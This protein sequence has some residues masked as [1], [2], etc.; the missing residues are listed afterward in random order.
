MSNVPPSLHCPLTGKVRAKCDHC[1]LGIADHPAKMLYCGETGNPCSEC[2]C[3][4]CKLRRIDD[5]S[6][7]KS[8]KPKVQQKSAHEQ[9]AAELLEQQRRFAD[10]RVRHFNNEKMED[11]LTIQAKLR[12]NKANQ[13]QKR[14]VKGAT[15]EAEN[16]KTVTFKVFLG[17]AKYGP[18]VSLVSS[19]ESSRFGAVDVEAMYGQIGD[20]VVNAVLTQTGIRGRHPN[21]F[22]L[23]AHDKSRLNLAKQ[24]KQWFMIETKSTSQKSRILYLCLKNET[25]LIPHSVNS[26]PA[27]SPPHTA[28]PPTAA[29]AETA[30]DLHYRRR[31]V[32]KRAI[33]PLLSNMQEE[34]LLTSEADFHQQYLQRNGIAPRNVGDF[35]ADEDDW[36]FDPAEEFFDAEEPPSKKQCAESAA[37]PVKKHRPPIKQLME[38]GATARPPPV[39]FQEGAGSGTAIYATYDEAI[40]GAFQLVEPVKSGSTKDVW[41][42][43]QV[44]HHLFEGTTWVLKKPK[45]Q[46]PNGV[47]LDG[48]A[49]LRSELHIREIVN[50]VCDAWNNEN[51]VTNHFI[52]P[53]MIL[54]T[55]CGCVSGVLKNMEELSNVW[56]FEQQI[57]GALEKVITN[58]GEVNDKLRDDYPELALSITEDAES[59]IHKSYAVLEGK[60]L[61]LDVELLMTATGPRYILD[62]QIC[63]WGTFKHDFQRFYGYGNSG[64]LGY[65]AFVKTHRRCFGKCPAGPY[66]RLERPPSTMT[67]ETTVFQRIPLHTSSAIPSIASIEPTGILS[68]PVAPP[69]PV[70]PVPVNPIVPSILAPTLN[71][72]AKRVPDPIA[73]AVPAPNGDHDEDEKWEGVRLCKNA[74]A[75]VLREGCY[76]PG[77]IVNHHPNE[78]YPFEVVAATGRPPFPPVNR[79]SFHLAFDEEFMT[80]PIHPY[81]HRN[82][83][84]YKDPSPELDEIVLQQLNQVVPLVQQILDG[85]R[86]SD[87]RDAKLAGNFKKLRLLGTRKTHRCDS[88]LAEGVE[89][90][91]TDAQSDLFEKELS[92]RFV[93]P[94]STSESG[95]L[96]SD[97]N[98][99]RWMSDVIVPE[100][101]M[102]LNEFRQQLAVDAAKASGRKLYSD[103]VRSVFVRRNAYGEGGTLVNANSPSKVLSMSPKKLPTSKTAG[104]LSSTTAVLSTPESFGRTTRRTPTM[105]TAPPGWK[106]RGTFKSETGRPL[107]A[108]VPA[109][110][111]DVSKDIPPFCPTGWDV[112]WCDD[113]TN[114]FIQPK[115][116]VG[117]TLGWSSTQSAWYFVDARGISQWKLPEANQPNVAP[118]DEDD[119]DFD[120]FEEIR[121]VFKSKEK[122][123]RKKDGTALNASDEET[124]KKRSKKKKKGTV[125]VVAQDA[126]DAKMKKKK[127]KKLDV[128]EE[129]VVVDGELDTLLN[130]LASV[131]EGNL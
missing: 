114:W 19:V 125:I 119:P 121:R 68:L 101:R 71:V 5:K 18:D 62:C 84:G 28:P 102:H 83:S 122:K 131:A 92:S 97:L 53:R 52:A 44:M 85:T 36:T 38:I 35:F 87:L 124:E 128:A 69:V 59:F 82:L 7:P 61:I 49:L 25:W 9:N 10:E 116:P 88:L 118:L 115:Y 106:V 70:A 46:A 90:M 12:A 20:D 93:I 21:E 13:E 47:P 37:P 56:V 40:L 22:D 65:R 32:I 103:F 108:V 3:K 89:L 51:D 72:P 4:G 45:I 86:P 24:V 99:I 130:V 29:A 8:S 33:R 42:N 127:K 31:P 15:L 43:V 14:R 16:A 113:I 109:D 112:Q 95:S 94:T 100:V 48:R 76:E 6:P 66:S 26:S 23:I 27:S 34:D 73:P 79:S 80:C 129:E 78:A 117:W 58:V 1:G 123:K 110:I 57:V 105:W 98:P 60:A 120:D 77:L 17:R 107:A 55:L 39:V 74:Y 75:L 96:A 54:M 81:F 67:I 104:I 126:E 2:P 30:T 63:F 64:E 91:L 41:M 50:A 111:V 11:P